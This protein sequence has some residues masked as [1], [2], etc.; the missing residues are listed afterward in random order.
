MSARLDHVVVVV[1]ALDAAVQ[2]FREAGFTVSPGGRHDVLPTENALIAFADGTYLELL[3]TRERSTR[4]E[5]R[6]LRASDR[7]SHH[8]RG[9]SAVARRFL[10]LL[11]GPDGVA[12]W[13][14]RSSS[15]A[16]DAARLRSQAMTAAGPVAMQRERPD[17]VTLAWDLLLPESFVPPFLI[18]DRT[19]R[20]F[21]VPEA[22]ETVTHASGAGGIACVRVRANLVPLA[23]LAL[24]EVLGAMPRV[25][26]SGATELAL[27]Q[28]RVELVADASEGAYAVT[29]AGCTAL[30]EAIR[31][32]GVH[33]E[34][35]DA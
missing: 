2:A 11:A 5:L 32:L 28:G 20:G 12:D 15:L 30:P 14:L 16:R 18:Q 31:A 8:L 21:R 22:S 35:A 1:P 24:G 4:E 34:P 17:G 29:L 33:P 19:P 27:A 25:L 3:A 23:A 9:V 26:D 6:A 10:P 7:W 13:V